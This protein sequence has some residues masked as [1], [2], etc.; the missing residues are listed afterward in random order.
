VK[1]T[2]IDLTALERDRE[3]LWAEAVFRYK[4]GEPWHLDTPELQGL[5]AIE[6]SEREERDDWVEITSNW[7]EAPATAAKLNTG[8]TTVDVLCGALAFAPERITPAATKRAGHTLRSLDFEP[9]QQ[10]EGRRRVRKYF[11]TGDGTRESKAANEPL[12]RVTGGTG[13]NVSANGSSAEPTYGADAS[14]KRATEPVT[15]DD[16]EYLERLAI[17]NE[18]KA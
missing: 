2:T 18:G 9:T 12:S 17:Q 7:L 13:K 5:A 6:Q 16:Y 10:R 8:I 1:C 4:R 14:P 3:Q 15:C 11:R